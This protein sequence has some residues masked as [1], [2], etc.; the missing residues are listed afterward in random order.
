MTLSVGQAT[1]NGVALGPSGI[2]SIVDVDG[3]TGLPTVRG[4]DV[5]RPTA[6]GMLAGYDFLGDR[7]VTLTLEVYGSGA[8]TMQQN[9]ASLRAAFAAQQTLGG[10]V[11]ATPQLVYNFGE[12]DGSGNGTNRL[13]VCRPRKFDAKVDLPFAAG[14]FVGGMA[15]VSVQLV[16]VDPRIYDATLQSQTVG[17]IVA[18]G[19]LTFPL[20]FPITFSAS[21]G[22]LVV[23]GNAGS[24]DCPPVITISGQCQNPRVQNQT[25]GQ[26][27]QFNFS[28]ISTD[29]LVLDCYAQTAT[30]NGTVSRMNAFAPGSQWFTIPPGGATLGFYSSDS[31]NTGA[32]M[33]VQWRN[34]WT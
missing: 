14:S 17:L 26:Q 21:T 9:L 23:A 13:L 34:A 24:I 12:A 10:G 27:V 4:N 3:L 19:G 7:T 32:T 8:T 11:L 30:F 1:F 6:T 29:V 22:G 25:T 5:V 33:Q 31:S 15:T 18:A 2:A 16:A 28:M 20:S